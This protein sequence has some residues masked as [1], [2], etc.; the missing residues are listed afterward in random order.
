MECGLTNDV[1]KWGDDSPETREKFQN[2][3]NL[4]LTKKNE[5]AGELIYNP[6]EMTLNSYKEVKGEADAVQAPANVVVNYHTHPKACYVNEKTI[7]GWPSGEDMRECIRFAM[8]G[9]ASHMVFGLEGIY[10]IRVNPCLISWLKNLTDE[11]RGLIIG[12]I[13]MYF[14]ATHIFRSFDFETS[15]YE[16]TGTIYYP[17][18]WTQYANNF[19]LQ[20]L[21]ASPGKTKFGSKSKAF[22]TFNE[23]TERYE[24]M[25]LEKFL[26]EYESEASYFKMGTMGEEKGDISTPQ[27]KTI[28]SVLVDLVSTLPRSCNSR[29][30]KC[31]NTNTN[32]NWAPGK[33]FQVCLYYNYPYVNETGGPEKRMLEDGTIP[34]P[35]DW[36]EMTV[37]LG[38]Q[39]EYDLL[40]RNIPVL[41]F[42]GLLGDC[43]DWTDVINTQVYTQQ[44]KR[45]RRRK[46]RIK[47][48]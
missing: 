13:E 46:R 26:R 9:S 32:N 43:N 20:H 12:T 38:E 21:I 4:C 3:L 37:A 42:Y 10:V 2:I 18:D 19:T 25:S 29:L 8:Q 40:V 45:K 6:N 41:Y 24:Q 15:W 22:P 34:T 1:V 14:K 39:P 36:M 48:K 5:Y 31:C 47:R 27:G 17:S 28:K 44:Q 11:D 7:W 30:R 16:K 35:E 23:E 33:W